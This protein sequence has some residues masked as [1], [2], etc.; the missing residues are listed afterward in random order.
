[1]KLTENSMRVLERR[2]LRKD[3]LGRTIETPEDMLWRVACCVAAAEK[4]EDRELWAD[5]FYSAMNNL[6]FL[7]NSPTLMNA[8]KE[9][10]QLAACFVLPIEDSMDG[11]FT[12]LK[13]TA[14]IHKS[15]GGT[16]FNFS[17]LRP[18]GDAVKST[19]G[20][21]SGPVSFMELF[22]HT[23]EIVMQGGM[24]RGAN[25]GILN[26]D[27]PDIVKFIKAKVEENRL[28]NFN[29][30]VGIKDAFMEAVKEDKD[31]GLVNPKSGKVVDTIKARDLFNMLVEYAWRTGDP[32][33]L[34]LDTIQKSNPI[35]GSVIEASNPCVTADTF[36]MTNEGPRLVKDLVGRKVT[37]LV[38]GKPYETTDAGFFKTGIKPVFLITTKEGYSLKATADHLI[39]C[40]RKQIVWVKVFDLK[41]GDKILRHD[42]S[43]DYECKMATIISITEAGTEEVYDVQVPGVN[44]FDANG[45]IVHNCGEEP[46]LSYESCNLGS[47]NLL[48]FYD[49]KKNDIDYVN[50]R[51]TIEVAVTFLDDVIDV[52]CFPIPEIEQATKAT[53]KIG[54]GIMGWADL[55]YKLKIPYDSE[56]AI[57]LADKL[58]G[59]INKE[60]HFC[61]IAL[62]R[63]KGAFPLWDKSIFKDEMRN[64]TLTT[65]APTGTISLIAG[66]SSGIEPNFALAYKRRAFIKEAKGEEILTYINPVLLDELKN[67]NLYSED[68]I[69]EIME[70]GSLKDIAVPDDLKQVFVTAHDI[71]P[72]WHIKMQAAFQKHIDAAVSKTINFPNN[73]TVDDVYNAF[74]LAYD[75]GCKGITVFRDGCKSE[76]VLSIGKTKEGSKLEKRDRPTVLHGRTAKITTSYGNLYLT[77]NVDEVEKPFEIFATLGK[78]GKDTQAHTEAIGRLASLALR[79]GISINDIIK[80][81]K[82]I[83]GSTQVLDENLFAMIFSVPDAIAKGLEMLVNGEVNNNELIR[84]DVCPTCGAPLVCEEGCIR[85]VSC[86]FSK[87]G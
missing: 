81:L 56:E 2:Y 3:D 44:A 75:L 14:L 4:P 71:S 23:T 43:G 45:F 50:L 64:A 9:N 5:A 61:S 19:N 66:V 35:K 82:G 48:N 11:I 8:G 72:E 79:S 29:I 62:A 51:D 34:F 65:I 42:H 33:L 86:G 30:S 58:M 12:T 77:L 7:P 32:G 18:Q 47:I 46:L 63:G 52:N 38:N 20:V 6:D 13:N 10:G 25:M 16:G 57:N 31:W 37:L 73:A 67:R 78:S 68:L 28:T 24:R 83:G 15:G 69:A 40:D 85:C 80:Q 76:Q 39:L 54:L 87:C 74:M 27:H 84:G 1:M 53:R 59:F 17:H 60:A 55:L 26:C 36:V 21:A 49:H 22:D 41:L 70:K